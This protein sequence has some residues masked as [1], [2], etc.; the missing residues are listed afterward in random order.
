MKRGRL[1]TNEKRAILLLHRDEGWKGVELAR[2]F[3]CS[4]GRISQIVRNYY[5]EQG[6]LGF[7]DTASEK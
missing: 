7:D 5:R 6:R 1:T 3:N 2:L 4:P